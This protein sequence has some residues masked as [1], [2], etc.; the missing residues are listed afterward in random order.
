MNDDLEYKKLLDDIRELSK[1][2]N[3]DN[4]VLFDFSKRDN[5]MTTRISILENNGSSKAELITA[6]F[7]IT[8]KFQSFITPV[9]DEFVKDNEI[10]LN[11]FVDVNGDNIVTYRVITYN[12]DQLTVDGL[13][14]DDG[15]FIQNHIASKDSK[16]LDKAKVKTLALDN[17]GM[18]STYILIAI[19]T[20]LSIVIGLLVYFE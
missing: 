8:N 11:D 13:T 19:I 18:M 14:F 20:V 10:A 1:V 7:D 9:L 15:F 6:K 4:S 12:N 16:S 3:K 2:S 5:T 17:K